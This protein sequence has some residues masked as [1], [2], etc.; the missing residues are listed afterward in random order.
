MI[1]DY[2]YSMY[3][4]MIPKPSWDVHF[5]TALTSHSRFLCFQKTKLGLQ[6][7][8]QMPTANTHPPLAYNTVL[9]HVTTIEPLSYDI[10]HGF[11]DFRLAFMDD[12][13]A[14]FTFKP[15]EGKLMQ[16]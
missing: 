12:I 3:R 2:Q 5:C 10:V 4:N 13:F 7:G 14:D 8:C 16:K 11:A 1:V 9:H 6:N 15:S